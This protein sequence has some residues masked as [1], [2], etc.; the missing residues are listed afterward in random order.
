MNLIPVLVSLV[1]NTKTPIFDENVQFNSLNLI[2]EII[3]N[4]SKFNG[5]VEASCGPA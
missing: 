3:L 1:S 2:E 4:T 5:I